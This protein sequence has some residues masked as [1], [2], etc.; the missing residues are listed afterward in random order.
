M[1][2]THIRSTT[3]DKSLE[4]DVSLSEFA[5]ST[6]YLALFFTQSHTAG[7]R[8]YSYLAYRQEHLSTQNVVATSM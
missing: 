7:K 5:P 3:A 4:G 2:S 8:L 1:D 6:F